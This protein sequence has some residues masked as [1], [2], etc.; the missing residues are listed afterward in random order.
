M[1]LLNIIKLIAL[2][3][4]IVY[5]HPT[6]YIKE[7]L[8]K[9]NYLYKLFSCCMCL[10]FWIGAAFTIYQQNYNIENIIMNGCLI[11]LLSFITDKILDR[12]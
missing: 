8:F 5:S 12:L 11:S 2:T 7:K 1:T 3:Y 4:I 10:G 6:N 9:K